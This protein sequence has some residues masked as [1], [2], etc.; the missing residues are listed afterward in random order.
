MNN[1]PNS[2]NEL[3][4]FWPNK[5]HS[6]IPENMK[7]WVYDQYFSQQVL[8]VYC[9]ASIKHDQSVI[10]IAC[11]YVANGSVIVKRKFIKPPSCY[12]SVPPIYAEMK[13]LI[14]AL[15][16]F[17]EHVYQCN[18]VII[19]SDV[20]HIDRILTNDKMF[21]K[22]L[23]LQADRKELKSLYNQKKNSF[24]IRLSIRYLPKSKKKFNPFYKSAHNA[25][26][27]VI[28]NTMSR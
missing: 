28:R 12:K 2:V 11:S 8:S 25:A 1:V 10:G 3:P 6:N 22:H 21:K 14:F 24:K 17:E 5:Y 13:S 20:N 19:Y 18:D 9:D 26:N 15:T 4:N 23:R 7:M 16:H 27:K